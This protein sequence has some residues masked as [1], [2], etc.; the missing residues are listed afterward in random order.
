MD[1]RAIGAAVPGGM[2]AAGPTDY[3][4]SRFDQLILTI[5]V[6]ALACRALSR[7]L[8]K[9]EPDAGSWPSRVAGPARKMMIRQRARRSSRS[10][11]SVILEPH[12]A[13]DPRTS[14]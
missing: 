4:T 5:F 9:R 7:R 11:P 13:A 2:H 6:L 1:G 8:V 12:A 3:I 14:A 10:A